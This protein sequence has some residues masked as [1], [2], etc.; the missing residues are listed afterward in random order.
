V[1]LDAVNAGHITQREASERWDVHNL[2]VGS[3]EATA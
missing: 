3:R 1:L 2:V